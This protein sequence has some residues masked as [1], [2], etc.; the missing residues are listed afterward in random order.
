M[1]E[2]QPCKVVV[3]F[4]TY[5]IFLPCS[6]KEFIEHVDNRISL[7]KHDKFTLEDLR[8]K[9]AYTELSEIVDIR[10]S[11]INCLT[12]ESKEFSFKLG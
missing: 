5:Y 4:E 3:N 7:N 1:R 8:A 9:H 2:K 12:G 11:K 10:K 6:V